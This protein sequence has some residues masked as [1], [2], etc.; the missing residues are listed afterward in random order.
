MWKQILDFAREKKKP[1]IFVIDDKKED[2]WQIECGETLGPRFEL[3]KELLDFAKVEFH[4]YNA[5]RFLEKASEHFKEKIE[6]E[7]INE[8][9][10]MR[11]LTDER[12]YMIHKRVINKENFRHPFLREFLMIQEKL[13]HRLIYIVEDL[14]LNKEIIYEIRKHQ[15]RV[16]HL[17][18]II[19]EDERIPSKILE[20][21]FH[22]EDRF[23]YKLV[24]Y[25][26][27]RKLNKTAIHEFFRYFDENMHLYRQLIEYADLDS[28]Y[29]KRFHV[30]L[31]RNQHQLRDY[32]EHFSDE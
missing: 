27:S 22:L 6:K 24:R 19:S 10:R 16:M 13:N 17:L 3:K 12:N 2:W 32:M 5:G 15:E 18:E 9:R 30:I 21:L 1:I 26:K 20:E 29:Y 23:Q 7:S 8:I 25:F 31:R 14:K 28:E 4:M 11:F